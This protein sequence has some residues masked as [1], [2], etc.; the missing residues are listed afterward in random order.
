[1]TDSN[2]GPAAHGRSFQA[3]PGDLW[4]HLWADPWKAALAVIGAVTLV[5]LVVLFL[6]PLELYPDE[7]Q[8]WLWS[9]TLDFGYWSKPPMVA[10][11][12][13]LTTAVGGDS[14]P[15][16]RLSSLLLQAVAALA[17]YK[18]GARL[19]GPKTGFWAAVT[20]T[21]MPGVQ[22]SSGVVSTDAGLLCFLSL[23][24]WA[25][26]VLWRGGA[27]LKPALGLG[28]A[29]GLAF[30]SKYAALYFIIGLGLHA[31]I[32]PGARAAWSVKRGATALLA[33][34]VL[35]LPNVLWNAAHKFATVAH[36]AENADLKGGLFHPEAL[37]KFI[38]DQFGVFG[39]V[40]LIALGTAAV[41]AARRRDAAPEDRLLYALAAPPLA[42]VT[43]LALLSRANANWAAAAYVPASVLVAAFIGRSPRSLAWRAALLGVQGL[44]CLAM[45]GAALSPAFADAAG[46]ANSLKRNRGWAETTR[47]TLARADREAALAPLDAVAADDRFLFYSLAYY[48]RDWFARPD[49]PPLKIWVRRARPGN[50]AEVSAPLTRAAGRRVVVASVVANARGEIARDFGLVGPLEEHDVRL[51]RKHTRDVVLFAGED[52]APK[53]RP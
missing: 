48:G 47:L 36:T 21:L 15:W 1:M 22:L 51:D 32:D 41:L 13:A 2:A 27:G 26:A 6:T 35:A 4:S 46:F 8:Y 25:Y 44:V 30:L 10:W 3:G 24:L 18:A 12:I 33:F 29:L 37:G 52:F 31:L 5:R 11:L 14:E 42:A 53:P 16:V 34:L 38:G 50:Q 39:P 43:V 45:L 20:W 17:L 49:A 7:A 23:A 28:A 19:C 9:R 40:A